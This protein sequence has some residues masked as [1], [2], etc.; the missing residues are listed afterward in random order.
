[1]VCFVFAFGR[2]CFATKLD[3]MNKCDALKLNR[4]VAGCELVRN[5]PNTTSWACWASSLVIWFSLPYMKFCCPCGLFWFLARGTACL[6]WHCHTKWPVTSHLKQTLPLR[7]PW[8]SAFYKDGAIG[9][10]SSCMFWRDGCCTL[11]WGACGWG[12]YIS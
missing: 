9:W 10:G 5:I 2:L 7:L 6:V 12:F 4:T 11:G 1:M 8:A 3:V